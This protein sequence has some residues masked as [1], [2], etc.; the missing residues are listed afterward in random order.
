MPFFQNT[1]TWFFTL[2]FSLVFCSMLA[3]AQAQQR[4]QLVLDQGLVKVSNGSRVRIYNEPGTTVLIEVG[5]QIH[6]ARDSQVRLVLSSGDEIVSLGA[7]TVFQ[8]DA[9]TAEDS[10]TRLLTGDLKFEIN[11]NRPLVNGKKRQFKIRTV[12]AVVGVRGSE[13][14]V[15][16]DPSTGETSV[17]AAAGDIY[18]VPPELEGD[19]LAEISIP[20]GQDVSLTQESIKLPGADKPVSK[21]EAVAQTRESNKQKQEE[22]QPQSEPQAGDGAQAQPQQESGGESSAPPAEGSGEAA[23]ASD[24]APAADAPAPIEE[25]EA[26]EVEAVE[27]EEVE[28]PDLTEIEELAAEAEEAADEALDA[29][30]EAIDED[31]IESIR[32]INIELNYTE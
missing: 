5:D 8:V 3:P 1:Q 27:I 24:E 30:E 16:F 26:V 20:P 13:G 19:T 12:T 22:P 21:E 28:L 10:S 2:L 25:P 4:G 9:A 14:D 31:L 23:P 17:V 32:E 18:V 7:N 6:T 15:G 11:P 29:V